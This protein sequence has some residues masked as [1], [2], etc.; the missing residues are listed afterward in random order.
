MTKSNDSKGTVAKRW[1][2]EAQQW[3]NTAAFVCGFVTLFASVL[4][5]TLTTPQ[6]LGLGVVGGLMVAASIVHIVLTS[7][8]PAEEAEVED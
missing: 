2:R 1:A 8:T 5:Q 7:R 6:A 4:F 3:V